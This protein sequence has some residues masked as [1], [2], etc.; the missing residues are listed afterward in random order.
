MVHGRHRLA[1]K[2]SLTRAG[3]IRKSHDADAVKHTEQDAYVG[4]IIVVVMCLFGTILCI[5][6][7]VES[8]ECAL[9]IQFSNRYYRMSAYANMYY[10][11]PVLEHIMGPSTTS[12]EAGFWSERSCRTRYHE[13]HIGYRIHDAWLSVSYGG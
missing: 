7:L 6:D 13:R 11:P 12:A 8:S 3:N 4:K 2:G 5:Q 10:G 1:A 9:R